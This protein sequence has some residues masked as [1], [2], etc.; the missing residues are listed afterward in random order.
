MHAID[1]RLKELGIT[2]PETRPPAANYL[3]YKVAGSTIYVSGQLPFQEGTM[4]YP[5]LVGQEV[6]LEQGREAARMAGLN[7][8]AQ[9]Y[10]ACEKDWDRLAGCVKLQGFVQCGEGFT[11]HPEVINGASDLMVE[12]LGE[13]GRH[14]RF[15]VGALSLPRNTC[16]EIDAIFALH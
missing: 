2:L 5:G 16:V 10:A 14:A 8:L 9:V 11:Q 3:P 7:I 13:A 12:V 1:A 15:A 6:T 4:L